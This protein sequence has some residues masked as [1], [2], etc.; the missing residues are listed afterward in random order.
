M[1]PSTTEQ[2]AREAIQA[3]VK[4]HWMIT[5]AESCTGGLIVGALTQIPGSSA[6]VYGG[7]V[8]YAN[9][10]KTAMVNVPQDM[11]DR[12]GAV[13]EQVAR[14]MS[15]GALTASGAD[16]SIAVTGIAGPDGG[17]Q[18]K[19]VGLVHIACSSAGKTGIETAHKEMRFGQIG[20]EATRLATLD[21]ALEMVIEALVNQA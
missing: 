10:A 5:T 7:Y 8:T 11:L 1:F 19:P 17:S 9:E 6:A 12:F 15:E 21:T 14:K 20:R 4:R 2:L 16:I 13:S 3:L 18:D